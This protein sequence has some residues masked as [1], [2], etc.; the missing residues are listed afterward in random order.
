M[1]AVLEVTDLS[2]DF[3]TDD[4]TV[5][6]VSHVSLTIRPG[7]IVGVVGESGCGKSTLAL[8]VLGLLGRTARV[9]GQVAVEGHDL[10]G[11]SAEGRRRLRG[12]RISMVPQDPLTSLDPAFSVGDLNVAAALYRALSL[13]L[14]RWPHLDAWLKRCWDRAP[15]KKARAMRE[16]KG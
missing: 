7:E 2:V 14:G 13:D 1:S 10:G 5:S 3:P 6:A 16:A 15:A 8:A 9:T 4:A 11:L 12:D